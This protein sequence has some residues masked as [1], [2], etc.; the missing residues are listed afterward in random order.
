MY[1]AG[2]KPTQQTLDTA[3][4]EYNAKDKILWS[5]DKWGGR[6]SIL[7]ESVQVKSPDGSTWNIQVDDLGAITAVKL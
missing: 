3:N 5:M 1:D 6:I 4:L 2:S 7:G